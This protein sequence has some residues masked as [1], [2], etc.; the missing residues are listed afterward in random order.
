MNDPDS[1]PAER[2]AALRAQLHHHA[3]LYHVLDAPALP[4]R[5]VM[6]GSEDGAPAVLV[7]AFDAQAALAD[8]PGVAAVREVQLSLD[9]PQTAEAAEPFPAWHQAARLL[10]ADMDAEMI[11]DTG[12]PITLHAFAA[13]GDDLAK[14]YAALAAHD[15][16][17][18]SAAARRLFA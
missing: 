10:A 4:G 16:A 14:L 6:P 12:R 17:A 5:L 18:G 1:S 3:H 9:V 11:D 8:D 15:L 7:L 2:A 13:I